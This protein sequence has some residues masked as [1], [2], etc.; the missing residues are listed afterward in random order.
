LKRKNRQVPH[1]R[2]ARWIRDGIGKILEENETILDIAFRLEAG[3]HTPA[4]WSVVIGKTI[5]GKEYV[6]GLVFAHTGRPTK[7]DMEMALTGARKVLDDAITK[8]QLVVTPQQAREVV[9]NSERLGRRLP[10]LNTGRKG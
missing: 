10:A 3:R 6:H 1:V 7:K 4:G 9:A 5:L 8:R 2:I